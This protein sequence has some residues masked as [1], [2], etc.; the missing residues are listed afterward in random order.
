MLALRA[1]RKVVCADD[2]DKAVKNVLLKAKG[3]APEEFYG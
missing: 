1:Q 2:F 3:G